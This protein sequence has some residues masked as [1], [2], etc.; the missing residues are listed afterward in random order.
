VTRFHPNQANGQHKCEH[1]G[2]IYDVEW[3]HRS[4]L[5]SAKAFCHV[6]R[7]LMAEWNAIDYPIFKLVVEDRS[8]DEDA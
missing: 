3:G 6:C 2:A 8:D 5:E 7:K 1:C 4:T